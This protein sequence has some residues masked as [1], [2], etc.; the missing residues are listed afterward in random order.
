[1]N[2]KKLPGS[3]DI[4]L[5]KYKTVIFIHGCFW[6]GHTC[7]YAALPT[8]NETFWF[9]KIAKNKERDATKN[10]LLREA[11]WHVV[12]VWQC[13]LKNTE[14]RKR[15]LELLLEQIRSVQNQVD[16]E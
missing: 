13:E 2:V 3:P 9:D 12:V 8:S 16:Y 10:S 11:G 6:H 14:I 7:K 5:S 15:R 1:V 4:V